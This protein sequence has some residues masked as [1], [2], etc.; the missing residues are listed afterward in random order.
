MRTSERI[1]LFAL[2]WLGVS[3]GVLHFV[4]T[5]FFVDMVPAALPAPE[6]LVHVSGVFEIL[7]GVGLLVARTRRF[8]AFG[9]IALFVAVFP[10]NINMAVNHI[11]P[12]G[13]TA[14]PVWVLW[15]R[16]PLQG[17]LVWWA[18]SVGKSA[19]ARVV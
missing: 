12:A 11:T 13:T 1:S 15:A 18:Y 5:Q 9:L 6:L 4:K 16:L 2:S 19:N 8:S 3:A 10:A 14:M 7:G 17:L